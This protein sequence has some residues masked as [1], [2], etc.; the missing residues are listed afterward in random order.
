M[1]RQSLDPPW[2]AMARWASVRISTLSCQVAIRCSLIFCVP[3]RYHHHG[4]AG[5]AFAA[6]ADNATATQRHLRISQRTRRRPVANELHGAQ[7]AHYGVNFKR[8]SRCVALRIW[9]Y[10]I[11][12]RYQDTHWIVSHGQNRLRKLRDL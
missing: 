11:Y 12:I 3:F 10:C 9:T 7:A 4:T 2:R 5:A 6:N 1:R 8:N